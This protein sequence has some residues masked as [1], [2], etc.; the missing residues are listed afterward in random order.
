MRRYNNVVQNAAGA[1]IPGAAVVV[2]TAAAPPGSGALATIYSDDGITVLPNSLVT[3]DGFGRFGFYAPYGKYDLVITGPGLVTYTVAAEEITDFLE[4]IAAKDA[5]PVSGVL[6]YSTP[7]ASLATSIGATTMATAGPNGNKY[8]VSALATVTTAGSSCTGTTILHPIVTYTDAVTG[9]VVNFSLFGFDGVGGFT[10]N[11]PLALNGNGFLGSSSA[12]M[13]FVI[14]V[15]ANTTVQ[16]ST[17]YTA[18]T[19]CSPAPSYT[20]LPVLTQIQ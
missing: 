7:S 19:G 11:V 5:Q 10:F 12:F 9:I 16:F 4:F 14:N 17:T 3:T 15:K 2:H 1:A 18:G 20:F 8:L 13:T 6:V